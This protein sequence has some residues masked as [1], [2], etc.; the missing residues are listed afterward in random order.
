MEQ[1]CILDM[2]E[3]VP[4]KRTI[5]QVKVQWEHY[6]PDEATQESEDVMKQAYPFLFQEFDKTE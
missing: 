4:Q 3:V 1:V 6:A 5:M 2:R